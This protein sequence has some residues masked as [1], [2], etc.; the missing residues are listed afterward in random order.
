MSVES[1]HQLLARAAAEP[2]FRGLL[3][4][5]PAQALAG[6]ELTEA[7]TAALSHL[8]SD[9]FDAAVAALETRE[10]RAQPTGFPP[11]NAQPSGFPP[12]Q[13]QPTGF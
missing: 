1:I 6:Y 8:T 9:S 7:E 3:F 12:V 5:D 11:L 10:S 13:R 4:A 2:E